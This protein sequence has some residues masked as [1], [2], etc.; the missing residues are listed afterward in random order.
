MR[1]QRTTANT[2]RLGLA[3]VI[4]A[5]LVVAFLP[6]TAQAA[7]AEI[8]QQIHLGDSYSAGNGAGGY[9]PFPTDCRRTKG[10][11]GMQVGASLQRSGRYTVFSE[12]HA[13]SGAIAWDVDHE[14]RLQE[15]GGTNITWQEANP[16]KRFHRVPTTPAATSDRTTSP[17]STPSDSGAM[18]ASTSCG[19]KP[20]GSPNQ[21]TWSP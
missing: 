18:S 3:A 11:W 12:N 14:E 9:A 4:M 5:S 17:T 8:I 15:T 10:S 7:P 2:I 20:T 21:R 13:C 19:P 6:V 16:R 1:D